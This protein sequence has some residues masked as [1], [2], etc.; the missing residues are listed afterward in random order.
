MAAK[1]IT[2]GPLETLLSKAPEDEE[3]R[4][5]FGEDDNGFIRF[6]RIKNFAEIRKLK[7]KCQEL[8]KEIYDVLEPGRPQSKPMDEEVLGVI[9]QCCLMESLNMHPKGQITVEKFYR[10]SKEFGAMFGVIVDQFSAKLAMGE[11]ADLT[12]AQ[13]EAKN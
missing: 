9:G 8:A 10:L 4:V 13:D 1:K 12:S 2:S 7:A 5:V 6:R 3:F 11:V